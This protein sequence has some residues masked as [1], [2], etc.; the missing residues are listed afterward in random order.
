MNQMTSDQYKQLIAANSK[1]K[2]SN[3][4]TKK[5]SK[6][7]AIRTK[8]DGISFPSKKEANYYTALKLQK[9]WGQIKDFHRQVL[10]D[11]PGGIKHYI[12]FMIIHNDDSREYIEI[13]GRDLPVGKM[14][15]KQCEQIYGIEIKLI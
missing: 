6:Y 5:T 8:V 4:K 11:L 10:R 13:K 14:K 9:E 7:K 1:R 3:S 2:A 15:R 12:D